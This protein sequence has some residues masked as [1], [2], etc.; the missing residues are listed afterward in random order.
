MMNNMIGS[1]KT[2]EIQKK[3]TKVS[4]I[5]ISALVSTLIQVKNEGNS[6]YPPKPL[7]GPSFS[8]M[9]Y[10]CSNSFGNNLD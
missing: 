3:C 10:S 2:K 6:V 1:F 4:E 5:Q 7:H 8:F 9:W